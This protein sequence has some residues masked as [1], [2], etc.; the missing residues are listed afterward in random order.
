MMTAAATTAG[1]DAFIAGLRRCGTDATVSAGIV[2]FTVVAAGRSGPFTTQAGVAVAEL[3]A[4]PAVP[5]HWV[6][7]PAAIQFTTTNINT[8]ETLPG[9]VRHSRQVNG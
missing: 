4:W 2:M 3:E 7:L 8:D 1:T 9:W 5:P 6:H